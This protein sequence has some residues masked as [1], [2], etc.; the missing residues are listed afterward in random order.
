[1]TQEQKIEQVFRLLKS[2]DVNNRLLAHK[3][4]DSQKLSLSGAEVFHHQGEL[5][6]HQKVFYLKLMEARF[7]TDQ[8]TLE[9]YRGLFSICDEC[10]V[11]ALADYWTDVEA[12]LLLYQEDTSVKG[13][14]YFS[15][16]SSYAEVYKSNI[17][18]LNSLDAWECQ[19]HR[20]QVMKASRHH[21]GDIV[22]FK[23]THSEYLVM[24][25]QKTE[26]PIQCWLEPDD[27]WQQKIHLK[28]YY[29]FAKDIHSR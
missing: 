2:A 29:E 22:C 20:R 21:E 10:F 16:K 25:R 5:N 23:K 6:H 11:M 24:V 28:V 18:Y 17:D 14:F 27:E 19:N 9:E 26:F 15:G 13:I 4:W 3:L 8:W 7:I 12:R 1:M